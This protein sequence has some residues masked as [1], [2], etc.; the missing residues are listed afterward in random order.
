[1]TKK[2]QNKTFYS[3]ILLY[4]LLLLLISLPLIYSFSIEKHLSAD[5]VYYLTSILDQEDFT[6]ISWSRQF[7]N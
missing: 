3:D 4:L 6:Y 5:G 7:S 1:M 2:S